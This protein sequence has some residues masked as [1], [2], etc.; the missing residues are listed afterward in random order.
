[1]QEAWCETRSL[2]SAIMP[3]AKGRR[4]TTKPPRC[5]RIILFSLILFIYSGE[6]QRDSDIEGEARSS[7]EPNMRLNPQI[8]N[9]AWAE[10][11]RSTA[12]TPGQP[13]TLH[14]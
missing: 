10:G 13:S 6:M 5:L 1:M 9:M 12:E 2:D 7:Q 4:S 14:S 3:W 8:G 11:M